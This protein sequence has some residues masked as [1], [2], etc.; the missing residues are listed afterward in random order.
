MSVCTNKCNQ[1]FI[2]KR[3]ADSPRSSLM[4]VRPLSGEEGCSRYLQ[5]ETHS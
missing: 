2:Y 1:E 5:I 3:I 4:S